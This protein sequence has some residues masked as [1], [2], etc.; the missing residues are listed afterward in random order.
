MRDEIKIFI[1][2]QIFLLFL[3]IICF[4]IFPPSPSSTFSKSEIS[5]VEV[6][7]TGIQVSD[8]MLIF[9]DIPISDEGY[10]YIKRYEA[11]PGWK[12]ITIDLYLVNSANKIR[13]YSN[14]W[15]ETKDGIIFYLY[16]VENQN[17]LSLAEGTN[18]F[19]SLP[20]ELKPDDGIITKIVVQVPL[21]EDIDELYLTYNV[22]GD[23]IKYSEFGRVKLT[24]WYHN[25]LACIYG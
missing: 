8:E 10:A 13:E 24:L 1:K 7:V 19:S 16:T 15:I 12:F 20:M 25:I 3:F 2:S 14:G 5:D 9:Y 18:S 22:N 6:W 11:K 21:S 17:N 4:L 23:D